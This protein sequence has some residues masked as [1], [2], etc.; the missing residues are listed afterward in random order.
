[1]EER[2]LSASSIKTFLQCLL[3]YYLRYVEKKPRTGKTDPLAFGTAMHKALEVLHGE[4]A[5]TKLPPSPELYNEIIGV[6]MAEATRQG[7]TDMNTYQ[8]G[9]DLLLARL[10]G[11][12]PEET[13]LGLEL[14]FNLTTPNGT[15]YTGMVDKLLALDDDTLVI[16]D[17]KTSRTALTQEEADTDI[18]FS[19]YDLAASQLFP[20]YKTIV[21]VFDYLRLPE[22]VTHRTIEQRRLFID[23]LDAIYASLKA[24][25]SEEVKP[26]INCF[27]PW[28]EFKAYCPE[29]VRLI[30]DPDIKMLPVGELS[31][32]DFVEHWEKLSSAKRVVDY[33]QRELKAEAY[34]RMRDNTAIR[35]GGQEIY[36]VQ[37]TRVNYDPKRVYDIV[38]P[39][40]FV[41]MTS[42]GKAAVDRF[43][44]D[45]P[46]RS[47][48]FSSASSVSFLSPSFRTRKTKES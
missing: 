5:K 21:C 19:M 29:Y 1:M 14:T 32:A 46:E 31:D 40:N 38:G 37:Q 25:P 18:Q 15:P 44:R 36:R 28:C 8:E 7:L 13:V 22:V 11:I 10:D 45:N 42:V 2:P 33:F 47:T 24:L 34:E 17:Y 43:I 4:V 41:Q 23:F 9:R 30:T 3:K 27:C 6:F 48:E 20:G 16:I 35:G 39:H 26:N 12:D